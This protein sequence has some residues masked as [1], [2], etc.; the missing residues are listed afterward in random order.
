[1][2]QKQGCSFREAD[3]NIGKYPIITPTLTSRK[4]RA[5]E[6]KKKRKKTSQPPG[7]EDRG[8]AE[9]EPVSG[10][11]ESVSSI[12]T[13]ARGKAADREVLDMPVPSTSRLPGT[14]P[15]ASVDPPLVAGKTYHFYLENFHPLS[16]TEIEWDK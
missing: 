5:G 3:W 8:I 16:H 6:A 13:R 2:G 12:V 1:M 4:R 10:T 9:P 15:V 7:A 14:V 11:Q